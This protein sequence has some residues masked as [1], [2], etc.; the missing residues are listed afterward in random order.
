MVDS[1]TYRTDGPWG[2]GIA[3]DLEPDEIDANFH[4]LISRLITIEDNP[5]AGPVIQEISLD[6][7]DLTMTLTD[8]TVFGPFRIP[9]DTLDWRGAWAPGTSYSAM[10]VLSV[11]GQGVFL[12]LADH[13]SATVF[14]PDAVEDGIPVYHLM[15]AATG[16]GGGNTFAVREIGGEHHTITAADANHYLRFTNPTGCFVS[17]PDQDS[18]AFEQGT[19]IAFKQIGG[20]VMWEVSTP[21]TITPVAGKENATAFAGA[22]AR[23]KYV[24]SGT[25][26]KSGDLIATEDLPSELPQPPTEPATEAGTATEPATEPTTEPATEPSTEPPSAPEPV[27]FLG[28]HHIENAS[29]PPATN[30]EADVSLGNPSANR[31]IGVGVHWQTWSPGQ[32]IDSVVIRVDGTPYALS[33]AGRAKDSAEEFD[34]TELWIGHVPAGSQGDLEV[35]GTDQLYILD[36]AMW[37]I[38]TDTLAPSVFVHDDNDGFNETFDIHPQGGAMVACQRGGNTVNMAGEVTV[39]K[40]QELDGWGIWYMFGSVIPATE[41]GTEDQVTLSVDDEEFDVMAVI[42]NWLEPSTE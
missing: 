24:G 28:L 29:D 26:D 19:E 9:V 2:S 10:D 23:L 1:L 13:V 33:R 32:E 3:R 18:V 17:I 15:M 6:G 21:D 37:A 22:L 4:T 20:I 31:K 35:T 40:D 14:D 7:R 38:H 11:E 8:G 30:V 42:V 39:H 36:M 5:P 34:N 25:W 16:G 41:A 27:A 12:V